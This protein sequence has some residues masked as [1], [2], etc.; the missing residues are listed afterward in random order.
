M[1][2]GDTAFDPS[3]K[4][5]IVKNTISVTKR[6]KGSGNPMDHGTGWLLPSVRRKHSAW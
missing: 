5:H 2:S 1:T 3:R 4:E 6:F